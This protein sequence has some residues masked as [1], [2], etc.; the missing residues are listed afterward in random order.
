MVQKQILIVHPNDKTTSF[1]DKIKNYLVQRFEDQIHHFNIY[2]NDDSHNQCIARIKSNPDNGLIIFFGH[3]KTTKLYGAKGD[4]YD[5]SD[6][7]SPDAI[8]EKPDNYYYNDD[9]INENNIDIFNGKKVFC[10]ACNSNAKVASFAIENGAKTFLG[11]GNIPT[12]IS[13][14]KEDGLEN[15]SNDI[16]KLMKTELNYIVKRSLEIGIKKNYTFNQL[17]DVIQFITNQ[18]IAH[19]LKVDKT[20]KVRQTLT[21]YLYMFKSNIKI[22]GDPNTTLLG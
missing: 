18:R 13:E 15:I 21:F 9:F 3:G 1:L 16:V 20:S 11:F 17:R 19:Y 14:F 5:E 10:L 6:F 22:F 7:V 12:S 2:P 8:A 4:L